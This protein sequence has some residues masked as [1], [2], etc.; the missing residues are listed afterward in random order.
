M[1]KYTYLPASVF[2]ITASVYANL[3]ITLCQVYLFPLIIKIDFITLWNKMIIGAV[4]LVEGLCARS[5]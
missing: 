5:I 2:I 3:K 1:A 4:V